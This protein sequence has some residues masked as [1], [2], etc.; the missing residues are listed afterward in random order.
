MTR[1][2]AFASKDGTDGP[3]QNLSVE[4]RTDRTA[5]GQHHQTL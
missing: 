4:K 1:F 5:S 3:A 2:N